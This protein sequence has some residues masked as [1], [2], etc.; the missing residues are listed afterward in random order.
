MSRI[1]PVSTTSPE[2]KLSKAGKP[3]PSLYKNRDAIYPKAVSGIA[4]DIKWAVLLFCLTVYY[5]LPWVRFD[6]GP[7]RPTQAVLLDI[8]SERFHFFGLELW[9]QDIYFLTGALIMAAIGLFLVT[10]LFGRVWCGYACPQTVWTDLFMWVERRIEGDRNERMRRDK[11]R[12][13]FDRVWRKT[14]KHTAW[15]AIAFWTG[16]AWIMFFVD[17]PTV[18]RQFWTGDAA[19]PVYGFTLLFTA[20][21]YLLAGWAREQVCTYMCP[22]PRFQASMLDEQSIIVT[23][24]GWR[25]EPRGHRRA[26]STEKL[27]DCIDCRA[28]VN[29]CPTGIDIRDGIQLEC[30]NCGLCIDACNEIMDKSGG[31]NWLVTWDTLSRQKAAAAGRHERLRLFRPRT[32]IYVTALV[33]AVSVMGG[34]LALRSH[35]ILS[36]QHDRAPLFVHLKDG[37][38]RNAYTIKIANK[39]QQDGTFLLSVARLED[40]VLTLADEGARAP[41]LTL[42]VPADSI[43]SFRVLA[44]ARPTRLRDG[45]E[46]VDFTLRNSDT[47]ERTTDASI[48]MG[49][50]APIR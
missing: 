8:D 37:S 11:A 23:Y 28:C 2:A 36:V 1:E 47:G 32:F 30:I 29:V 14:A 27:G 42:A 44:V 45:S 20:T 25:G 15:L 35:Q 5:T 41:S 48:F 19:T 50:G 12:L 38:Y 10:S 46:D 6:R 4:R 3:K 22:W 9:P 26:D 40:G 24:Q 13:S 31:E 39:T 43:A 16:G 17:A 21:T 7:G 49:P 18:T 33:L 34:A